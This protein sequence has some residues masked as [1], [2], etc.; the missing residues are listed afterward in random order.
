M[1]KMRRAIFI[2]IYLLTFFFCF[3]AEAAKEPDISAPSAVLMDRGS[4]RVL[5]E[6]SAHR[7]RPIAS[8]TKI[9]T[10]LLA[11]E[12]GNEADRIVAGRAAA[13]TE[14]T[15]I[16]LEKGEVKTLDE[17]LYGLML[18]S[19]NDAAV[20]IAVHIGGS[21]KKFVKLMNEKAKLLGAARTHF[22]NPHG[23]PDENHYSTAYDLALISCAALENERFREI[24]ATPACSISWPGHSWDRRLNNQNKLLDSYPGAD[25]VKTGWTEKAGRCLVGSATRGGWQLVSVVLSAPQ[26]WE[27]SG[28]LLDYGFR[29]FRRHKIFPP[30]RVLCTAEVA[31][32]KERVGL[33]LCRS[34]H[35][36]LR[37]DETGELRYR[38]TPQEKIRAPLNKGQRLGVLELYRGEELLGQAD[39]CAG[40]AVE[41]IGYCDYL[42]R[43]LLLL[44]QGG[45]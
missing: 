9:M 35:Y 2:G 17:L 18:C 8:T 10:A 27:D 40:E 12:R 1:R 33:V 14:G 5:W 15:S 41:K 28:L 19:G 22:A 4:R 39:L 20:A 38:I 42:R 13:E 30:H 37:A 21:E 3:T 34:F 45:R 29:E 7:R 31:G 23:L 6:K 11:L 44:L 26:M 16:Y 32:T 24:V 25:G 43:L 36:P